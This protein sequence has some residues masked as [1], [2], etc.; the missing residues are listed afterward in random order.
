MQVE[1]LNRKLWRTRVE[2]ANAIF[3]YIGGFHNRQR[4]H[5]SLGWATPLEFE[6]EHRHEAAT[7]HDRF[8]ETG[9]SPRCPGNRSKLKPAVRYAE[10][11]L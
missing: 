1:L 2:L 4:L 5:S 6:N 9:T 10:E 8:R 7:P 3:E 11:L